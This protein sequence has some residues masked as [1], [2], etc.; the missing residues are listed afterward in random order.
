M[1]PFGKPEICALVV[2]A[3]EKATEEALRLAAIRVC[4]I[5]TATVSDL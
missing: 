4:R 5:Q 3:I 2:G 1:P